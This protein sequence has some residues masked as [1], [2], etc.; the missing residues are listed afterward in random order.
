MATETIAKPTVRLHHGDCL[1]FLKTLEPGSVDAVVTDPPYCSG[2]ATEASR[3]QAT[4]QGLRSET[5]REGRS[6]WFEG[7]N[8]TTNGLLWLLRSVAVESLKAL[9]D[10]GSILMFC[11]WRM[12]FAIGPAVESAGL[13]M[14]NLVVWDKG[15][16][17]LGNGF[18]PQHELILHFTRRS[19]EFHAVNVGNVI[20][21][22][23]VHS[24]QKDHACEKPVELM[25]KLISVV[26]P[27]GG[28][29][30]D[31][32]MGSA[33]TGEA[34]L[35]LGVNFIGCEADPKYFA[36]AKRRIDEASCTLF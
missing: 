11:D 2:G 6:S 20:Q 31:P 7:D 34:C 3:S 29:V 36:I 15:N 28:T 21:S 1:E 17:G 13:R 30:L 5:I 4:H 24:T 19:A 23:R 35:D 32:F 25:R 33:T 22:S 12:A 8:M 16:P 14:R 9:R 10:G 26:A 18:R 27:E